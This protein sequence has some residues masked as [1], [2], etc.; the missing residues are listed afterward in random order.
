MRDCY[1][2]E[3]ILTSLHEIE[4]REESI[5]LWQN[6]DHE[7][8]IQRAYFD[9]INL[10]D[11]YFVLKPTENDFFDFKTQYPL[12]F[13]TQYKNFLLKLSINSQTTQSLFLDIPS[14]AMAKEHRSTPRREFNLG[15]INSPAMPKVMVG[16][17]QNG[18]V[19]A[20]RDYILSD[21]STSGMGIYSRYQ[22][23]LQLNSQ[24]QVIVTGIAKKTLLSAFEGEIIYRKTEQLSV[25]QQLITFV[26]YGIRFKTPLKEPFIQNCY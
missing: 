13:H 6:I 14:H 20:E 16:K 17:G 24:D 3:E 22:Q 5:L 19:T 10:T 15:A 26:R 23:S 21:I 18:K 1:N 9:T 4:E 2:I 7:R 12:Y 8:F 25:N 11:D